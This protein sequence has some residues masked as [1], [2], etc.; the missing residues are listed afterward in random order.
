MIIDEGGV[1]NQERMVQLGEHT[2][3]R[4]SSKSGTKA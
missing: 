3:G 2:K 1:K 4:F